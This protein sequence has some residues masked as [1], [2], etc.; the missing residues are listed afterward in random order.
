MQHI[1]EIQQNAHE[2]MYHK[3]TQDSAIADNQPDA[4]VQMQ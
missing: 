4:F 2:N 3:C 1:D